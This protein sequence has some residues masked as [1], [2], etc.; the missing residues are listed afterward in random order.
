MEFVF[1]YGKTAYICINYIVEKKK[2]TKLYSTSFELAYK[3]FS[4]VAALNSIKLAN[5]E[6]ELLAFT[7]L[8]G[9]ISTGG[10]K[11]EFITQ[12][13]SSMGTIGNIIHV[14]SGHKLLVKKDKKYIVNPILIVDF[15][16]PLEVTLNLN[17]KRE[18]I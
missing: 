16:Q 5:R 17:A 12:Y 1:Y 10:A 9:T 14:L 2:I 3:Y 11:H 18:V 6:L 7:A 8:K 4:V 13:G 15:N